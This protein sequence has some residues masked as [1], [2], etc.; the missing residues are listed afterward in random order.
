MSN[1]SSTFNIR[2]TLKTSSSEDIRNLCKLTRTKNVNSD[3]IIEKINSTE[4]RKIAIS[5][6]LTYPGLI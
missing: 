5:K 6:S 3:S 1:E 2:R 4:K